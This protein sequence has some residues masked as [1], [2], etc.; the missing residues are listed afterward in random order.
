MRTLTR[1]SGENIVALCDVDENRAAEAFKRFPAAKRFRDYRKMLD[2]MHR[3]IDAVVVSIPDHMHAPVSLAA[4]ELGKHVYCEKP[5]TWSIDEARRW[6]DGAAR[7]SWRRRWGRRE[8]PQD[9]AEDGDR[10][11]PVGRSR[12]RYGIARLD[13]SPTGWW[14]QGVDRPRDK[15]AVPGRPGLEFVAGRGACAALPSRRIALSPGG[16]GRTSAPAPPATWGFTTRPCRLR[17][18][19]SERRPRRRLS[20]R[21]G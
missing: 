1:L 8:W 13:G 15:A 3:Q 9:R 6:P 5:L 10:D 17:R 14:P 4:M 12:R 18:S 20:R 7:R 2:A 19:S 21:R 11:H 16:D